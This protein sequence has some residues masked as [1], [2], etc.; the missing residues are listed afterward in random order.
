[1]TKFEKKVL[2]FGILGAIIYSTFMF[3][4]HPI[5][6]EHFSLG[7]INIFVG[8]VISACVCN[9]VLQFHRK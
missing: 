3:I 4:L 1:M 9:T 6:T 5:S 7:L 2:V 8:I